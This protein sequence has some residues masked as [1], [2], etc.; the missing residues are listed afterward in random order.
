MKI[1]LLFIFAF[2]YQLNLMGQNM[3]FYNS[4]PEPVTLYLE[5]MSH[6][7]EFESVDSAVISAHSNVVKIRNNSPI[8]FYTIKI[9]NEKKSQITFVWENDITII[10]DKEGVLKITGSTLTEQWSK[11]E[12]MQIN[13]LR[14]QLMQN[15]IEADKYLQ[16]GDTLGADAQRSKTDNLL[17]KFNLS[18]DSLIFY[19]ETNFINLYLLAGRWE[20]WA[21]NVRDEQLKKYAVTWNTHPFYKDIREE[22]KKMESVGEGVRIKP[23]QK[24]TI[25]NTKL[26]LANVKSKYILLD[27][28]GSWCGPCI[29][30]IPELQALYNTFDESRL[31][32]IG[33]AGENSLPSKAMRDIITKKN[34]RWEQIEELR[35]GK[36]TLA[37]V[38]NVTFYPT[39]FLLDRK[40]NIIKR[41]DSR[42]LPE[43]EKI[44][45][46]K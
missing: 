40:L 21:K 26:D 46:G 9:K 1:S 12:A 29:K 45:A 11:F 18:L 19:G 36:E 8:S 30:A 32:I 33:I 31:K 10:N 6:Y 28:W 22:I 20:A 44:V 3:V 2:L 35:Q 41:G 42:I 39:Y 15:T 38:L 25:S 13:P 4:A 27:F 23:F 24:T 14:S 37:Q 17:K 7:K 5:M 43:V 16:A 34:I